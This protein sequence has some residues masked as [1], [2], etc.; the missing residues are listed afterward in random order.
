MSDPSATQVLVGIVAV[1]LAVSVLVPALMTSLRLVRLRSVP[2]P[3]PEL[4]RPTESD[5]TYRKLYDQFVA[6]GF[7]PAGREY[8]VGW[9]LS[10]WDWRKRFEQRWLAM[11][12]GQTFVSFSKLIPEEPWRFGA[13]TVLSGGCVVRTHCPGVDGIDKIIPEYRFI[14]LPGADPAE[15][16]ARHRENVDAYCLERGVSIV[17]STMVEAAALEAS[18]GREVLNTIPRTHGPVF[19]TF[20]FMPAALTVIIAWI[21]SD[22]LR[23]IHLAWAIGIPALLIRVLRDFV[24]APAVRRATLASHSDPRR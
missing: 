12:D 2:F 14:R 1:L 9:F 22:G 10:A 19:T 13:V 11:P 20:Y 7:E 23:W 17:K 24:L 15:L 5:P 21:T 4:A 8:E 18:R 6:L 3:D 16:L